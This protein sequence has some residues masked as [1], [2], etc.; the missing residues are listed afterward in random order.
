MH[1]LGKVVAFERVNQIPLLILFNKCDQEKTNEECTA[2]QKFRQELAD[3]RTETAGELAIMSISALE[4]L[5]VEKCIK[6]LGDA[7]NRHYG[8]SNIVVT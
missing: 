3:E 8:N 5:N 1:F 4:N 7:I 2:L 6:W